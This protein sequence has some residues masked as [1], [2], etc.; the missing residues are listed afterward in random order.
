M[1]RQDRSGVTHE[2]SGLHATAWRPVR[3][4]FGE[5]ISLLSFYSK[6]PPHEALE[7]SALWTSKIPEILCILSKFLVPESVVVCVGLWLKLVIRKDRRVRRLL[8]QAFRHVP[9]D[10]A[11]SIHSP[12][13]NTS[14]LL[15]IRTRPPFR[16][17]PIVPKGTHADWPCL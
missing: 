16:F 9:G 13:V 10:I 3:R 6:D 2:V 1:T 12:A 15:Q 4:F 5:K 14:C 11:V 7:R 17:P 8:R